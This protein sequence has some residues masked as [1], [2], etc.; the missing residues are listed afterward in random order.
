M[1]KQI[2]TLNK[3]DLQSKINQFKQIQK[4]VSVPSNLQSIKTN[5]IIHK[6]AYS[7]DKD[8][9]GFWNLKKEHNIIVHRELVLSSHNSFKFNYFIKNNYQYT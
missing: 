2:S 9:G 6:L 4:K 3:N 7:V 8:W 5:K 1:V